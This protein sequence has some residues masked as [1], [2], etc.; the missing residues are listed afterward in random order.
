[1]YPHLKGYFEWIVKMDLP[2]FNISIDHS[3]SDIH[4]KYD[5]NLTNLQYYP[6]VIGEMSIASTLPIM[7]GDDLMYN[8]TFEN[9]GNEPAYD[10]EVVYGEFAKNETLGIQLPFAKAGLTFDVDKIM[11]YNTTTDIL[12]DTE[13]SGTDIIAIYG[14][15]FNTTLGDWVGNNQVFTGEEMDNIDDL[16]LKE[17]LLESRSYGLYNIY[18]RRQHCW[19]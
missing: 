7:E 16:I 13:A 2:L 10:I 15:F 11:Y 1:M 9:V 18:F 8:F 17:N 6:Q 4:V 19:S 5:F 14:W 12:S 3:Y